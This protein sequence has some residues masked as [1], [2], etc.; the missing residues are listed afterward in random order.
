MLASDWKCRVG[1]GRLL[2]ATT[3]GDLHARRTVEEV[4][5]VARRPSLTSHHAALEPPRDDAFVCTL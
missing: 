5:A 1:S 2:I 4:E 3:L